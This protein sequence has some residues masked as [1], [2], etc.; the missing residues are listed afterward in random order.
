[1]DGVAYFE[2]ADLA[3]HDDGPSQEREWLPVEPRSRVRFS[4]LNGAS[5]YTELN[6][7]LCDNEAREF[8]TGMTGSTQ[9]VFQEETDQPTFIWD[10][11]QS[12][13]YDSSPPPMPLAGVEEYD[14]PPRLRSGYMHS[15]SLFA[16]EEGIPTN[17]MSFMEWYPKGEA[18]LSYL[19]SNGETATIAGINI[20]MIE[21]RCPLLAMAFEHRR[22][23]QYLHLETLTDSTAV[24]FVRYLY[25]GSYALTTD[26]GDRH[27]DVPTS[28]L[29][30]CR[31]YHLAIMYDITDLKSQA[32]LNVLR[33]CEFGC[34]SPDRPIDLCAGIRYAYEH[35]REKELLVDALIN[36]CVSQFLGHRLGQDAEF[37]GLAYDLRPFHQAL[38]RNTAAAIIQMPFRSYT[39]DGYA[40]K[41]I[42]SNRHKDVIYHF[43]A[44]DDFEVQQKKRKQK[45]VVPATKASALS[46][47]LRLRKVETT[48]VSDESAS[49]NEDFRMVTKRCKVEPDHTHED[50]KSEPTTEDEYEIVAPTA[51][52]QDLST[53]DEVVDE[54]QVPEDQDRQSDAIMENLPV[55]DRLRRTPTSD[56]ADSD[57]DWTVL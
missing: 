15:N 56:G 39:P 22:S 42:T 44:Q 51:E 9:T 47:A 23:G 25:T 28:V 6:D 18:T 43:H 2:K 41:D 7:E 3:Y 21:A 20:W 52:V 29:L 1:M 50:V 26:F 54:K 27:D 19:G 48:E 8:D 32:Y 31:L 46:L 12:R 35:L 17:E 24:P 5:Q 38:C 14:P 55:H 10:G 40:S 37:Q 4:D 16:L 53:D 33:Q 49:E 11:V 45:E 13:R 30:H 34:S 36:Y 57:S